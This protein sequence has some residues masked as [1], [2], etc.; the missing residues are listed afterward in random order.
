MR[1]QGRFIVFTLKITRKTTQPSSNFHSNCTKRP[2][3]GTAHRK[4]E[5]RQ[6]DYPRTEE[7]RPTMGDERRDDIYMEIR[8]KSKT[9]KIKQTQCHPMEGFQPHYLIPQGCVKCLFV[10]QLSQDLLALG[11]RRFE[12]AD[13]VESA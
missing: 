6:V 10:F 13:H 3:P 9:R 1:A 8:G 4:A 5:E 12:V 2:T 11:T 7:A